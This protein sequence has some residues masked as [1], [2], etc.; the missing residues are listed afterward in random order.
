M[1]RKLLCL[2]VLLGLRPA[3]AADLPTE[4]TVDMQAVQVSPHVWYVQGRA[5]AATE[6]QGFI[7]NAG[8]V[9]TDAGVVVVDSL[10]TPALAR[11]LR[12]LIRGV[13]DQPVVKVVVTHYHADHI[14]GL[15]VFKQEGAEVLAPQG[16]Y[17]YLDSDG[18]RSRLEERRVSLFP[19][20]DDNTRLIA[21]DR[22]IGSGESFELGGIQFQLQY[23]GA[24]H[25]DGDL[26]MFVVPD[27]VLFSGDII[28]E[29]RIPFVGDA[30]TKQWLVSL[31]A[32]EQ[33]QLKALIPGHGGAAAD[34]N[35]AV[36]A[37]REYIADLRSTMSAAVEELQPFAEA[38]EAADWSKYADQP[39]FAEAHRRNAYQVYLSLEAESLASP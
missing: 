34:P 26:S 21:P 15:Q 28:F 12:E 22:M 2:L 11:Q 5:G 29:G 8:F 35:K 1:M 30:D 9:V 17:A 10:G 7:S 16:A 37:T 33:S 36:S 24:A 31:E 25:S 27:Q 3:I 18:A 4:P 23:L 6:Y 39:A 13:T 14:Y 38:Y 19:W 20:V 32:M